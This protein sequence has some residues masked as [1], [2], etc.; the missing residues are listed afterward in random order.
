M[1]SG[2]RI[3]E[4]CGIGPGPFCAMHLA[5]LGADVIAVERP[6]STAPGLSAA[7]RHVLN[8]GKRSIVADLKTPEGREL[9]LRLIE[10]ADALIE[11][12]RP[13]VMER[14][15]LGPDVCMARNPRLVFGRMTGWGQTGPLAQAAGHDNN[16]ISLSGA[17]YYAGSAAEPPSSP[18]TVIGDV[19]GGALY[20]AVGILSGVLNAR[21]TG[22]GT[23]VDAA[24]VDGSAHMLQLLLGTR[25]KGFIGGE[26]GAS[27]HD[28]SHFYSTYRCADGAYITVG[29][30]EP[31]FYALLLEHL[32]L[33]ADPRYSSQWDRQHWPELHSHLTGIFASKTR[34]EWCALLESTDVCF[35][36]VLS[37]D[38]AARHPHNVARG[39]YFEE[40]G[41]LQARPAPRFDGKAVAPG[42][43][44]TRGQ[45]TVEIERALDDPAQARLWRS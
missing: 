44:P 40:D 7:D 35:A 13:G 14:L 41:E 6:T 25:R 27:M 22:K 29:A 4:I 26:R 23:V 30:L 36:P 18:I 21:S 38:E 37:P 42:P 45:H 3:V 16:Y 32:G 20:L 5:D 9:V 11:G 10:D 33:T 43:I 31:Q 15:G 34:A 2:L 39:I 1:L 24:I 19:G 8:R 28:S 17:L 12:M